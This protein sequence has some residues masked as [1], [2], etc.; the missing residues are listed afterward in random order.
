ME[1]DIGTLVISTSG[2]DK[3]KTLMII[4]V[5]DEDHV[6]VADG[7][8]R[9]KENPKLKKLKHLKPIVDDNDVCIKYLPER[10]TN[11]SIRDIIERYGKTD[12][13]NQDEKE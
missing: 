3:G 8:M 10:L 5:I 7:M 1:T 4:E 11:R 12:T 9:R 2:R 6:K 13:I